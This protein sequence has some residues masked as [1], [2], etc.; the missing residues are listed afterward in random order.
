MNKYKIKY[1]DYLKSKEWKTKRE[2][3]AQE[4]NYICEKCKKQIIKG[5][6]IHHINYDNFGNE[7]ESDL[8]FLCKKCHEKIHHRENKAI[9]NIKMSVDL[10][11]SKDFIDL[12]NS[13]KVL[14]L[15][16][17]MWANGKKKFYYSYSLANKVFGSRTTIFRVIK[18][19]EQKGFI[20]IEKE[21]NK[22]LYT[23][24]K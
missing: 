13:S 7:K 1:E 11:K 18:E 3:I 17:K 21:K 22:N 8:M 10:L 20:K 9:K 23:F 4:R 12:T 19:L 24:L 16:M 14:Y 2:K 15:Y 6:H 5:Y